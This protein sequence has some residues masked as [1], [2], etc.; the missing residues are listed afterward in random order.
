MHCRVMTHFVI[1]QEGL[2][3]VQITLLFKVPYKMR[4]TLPKIIFNLYIYN[5]YVPTK[6]EHLNVC[7][8]YKLISPARIFFECMYVHFYFSMIIVHLH[9]QEDRGGVT[10]MMI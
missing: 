5:P 2:L 6:F 8:I 7:M 4:P 1:Y 10:P 3:D 9:Y